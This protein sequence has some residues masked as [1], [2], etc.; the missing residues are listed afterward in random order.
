MDYKKFSN[1]NGNESLLEK[2]CPYPPYV[3]K[4]YLKDIQSIHMVLDLLRHI[5]NGMSIHTNMEKTEE[6]KELLLV[7]MVQY[8][9]HQ[10]I[11]KHGTE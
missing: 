6:K 4:A 3:L 7:L 10:T 11:I 8:G 9:I 1:F 5:R 2:F